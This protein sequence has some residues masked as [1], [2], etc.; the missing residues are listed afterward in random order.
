M[1][2][3]ITSRTESMLEQQLIDTEPSPVFIPNS[4]SVLVVT[5]LLPED[6][7]YLAS[8]APKHPAPR[9]LAAARRPQRC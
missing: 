9:P 5:T 7:Q 6:V 3:L 4:V 1:P 2:C 8:R